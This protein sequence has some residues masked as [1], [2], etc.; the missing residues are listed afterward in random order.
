MDAKLIH[1]HP[2]GYESLP[3]VLLFS[4]VSQCNLNFTHCISRPT[5]TKLRFAWESIWNAVGK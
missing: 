2:Q 1:S 3:Q 5:R 4:P